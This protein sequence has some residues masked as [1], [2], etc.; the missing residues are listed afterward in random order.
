MTDHHY[1]FTGLQ[2]E[3][4]NIPVPITSYDIAEISRFFQR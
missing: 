1:L 3:A 2:I 4:G